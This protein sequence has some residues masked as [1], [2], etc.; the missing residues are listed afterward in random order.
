VNAVTATKKQVQSSTLSVKATTASRKRVA[1]NATANSVATG[2]TKVSVS[3]TSIQSSQ[4]D[5]PLKKRKVVTFAPATSTSSSTDDDTA[6]SGG[7]TVE[8]KLNRARTKFAAASARAERSRRRQAIHQE[9]EHQQQMFNFQNHHHLSLPVKK[10]QKKRVSKGSTIRNH[11]RKLLPP[12][13]RNNVIKVPMLTGTLYLYQG[14]RR[15]AEF[16]RRV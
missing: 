13:D 16:V 7:P 2:N 1:T 9:Q 8:S 6:T 12:V 10:L 15:H 4:D 11:S 5:I 3:P 14:Q